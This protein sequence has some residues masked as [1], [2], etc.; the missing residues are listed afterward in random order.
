MIVFNIYSTYLPMLK[1]G[2]NF[3]WNSLLWSVKSKFIHLHIEAKKNCRY[4]IHFLSTQTHMVDEW[5]FFA[6]TSLIDEK[7]CVCVYGLKGWLVDE[8]IRSRREIFCLLELSFLFLLL[9]RH[10]LTILADI[11]FKEVF[12]SWQHTFFYWRAK[13]TVYDDQLHALAAPLW[14]IKIIGETTLKWKTPFTVLF[15][16][17]NKLVCPSHG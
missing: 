10:C 14:S 9:L 15:I 2:I 4:L 13:E 16:F 1:N 7:F 6:C 12:I 17:F 8:W 5:F 3:E 11:G